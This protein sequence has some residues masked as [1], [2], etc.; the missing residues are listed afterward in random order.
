MAGRAITVVIQPSLRLGPSEAQARWR[1]YRKYVAGIEGPTVAVVQDRDAPF[2]RGAFWGEVNASIHR[3]F[4]C[5]GSVI[6]GVARDTPALRSLSFKVLAR[7]Q[8]TGHAHS[9]PLEWG[10][11]VEVFGCSIKP[12]QLVH[13]DQHGFLA[14]PPEDE[15]NLLEVV[16]FMDTAERATIIKAAQAGTGSN[17]QRLQAIEDAAVEFQSR[18]ETRY[19]SGGEF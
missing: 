17:L 3:T 4:G 12:G 10:E 6:D 7:Q 9:A 19:G 11:P 15:E 5:V 13:A 2:A 18:V 16:E 8:C 1:A 14:I